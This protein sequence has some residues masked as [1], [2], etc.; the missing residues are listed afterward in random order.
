M[1]RSLLL[2]A[3]EAQQAPSGGIKRTPLQKFDVPG[4]NYETVPT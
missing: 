4:Q 2:S 1:R 3:A